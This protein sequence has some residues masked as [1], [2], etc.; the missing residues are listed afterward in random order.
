MTIKPKSAQSPPAPKV[1]DSLD[2]EVTDFEQARAALEEPP[3]GVK[4]LKR[5]DPTEWFKRRR[6]PEARDRLLTAYTEAWLDR[7]PPSI[8][9]FELARG[10]P[11]IANRLAECWGDADA[12]LDLLNELLVDHRGTRRGFPANVALQIVAL[13][14][15]R[16]ATERGR[17]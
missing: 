17:R 5:F 14:D 9:P 12:C 1:L 10:Y 13:R 11:R 3:A 16:A 8:R 6:P 15:H 2:F 4:A 7:L